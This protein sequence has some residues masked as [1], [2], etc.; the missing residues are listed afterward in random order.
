MTQ[1]RASV[2][3]AFGL[4]GSGV[5]TRLLFPFVTEHFDEFV[6]MSEDS[7]T[8]LI[9]FLEEWFVMLSRDQVTKN[10]NACTT[11]L[12]LSLDYR[13]VYGAQV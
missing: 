12:M 3:Q 13:R 4:I 10:L 5:P 2:D 11:L 1:L 8:R 6:S 7:A 9:K